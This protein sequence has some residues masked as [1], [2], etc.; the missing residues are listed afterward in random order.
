MMRRNKSESSAIRI[1]ESGMKTYLET[2]EVSRLSQSANNARD[3][4]LI[5]LLSRL[6]CR[7][8]EALSITVEDI[9]LIKG[10]VSIEHLKTR[11][12]LSCP[13][14]NT[15]LGRGHGYG[16][17]CGTKVGK[18]VAEAKEHRR[19]RTLPI[20]DV[21]RQMLQAYIQ[22]GGPVIRDNKR[23][24]FGINRHRA[25][26]IIRDCAE[27]AGLPKLINSES[28][29]VHG[30]SPHKLRDAFAVHAMR[31]DDSGDGLRL[32]QEHLGHQ[33]FNTTARYRK[34]SGTEHRDWYEKLWQE[35]KTEISAD[36]SR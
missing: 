9:D 11:L 22:S 15:G 8:S 17:K 10:L 6:G 35:G 36:S 19:L 1:N 12:K 25:W 30:V 4:L 26:Q 3:V 5:H 32:L 7:I 21:T 24:I 23:L 28:G 31:L 34:I 27:R 18:A 29:K 16:P 20:D 13:V 14:C 2:E 33:N